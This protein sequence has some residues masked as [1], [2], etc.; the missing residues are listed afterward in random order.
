MLILFNHAVSSRDNDPSSLPYSGN[1]ELAFATV[2][3]VPYAFAENIRIVDD[4]FGD[5]GVVRTVRNRLCRW[6]T[7]GYFLNYSDADYHSYKA[8]RISYGTCHCH[9][10]GAGGVGGV[11]LEQSLLSRSKHRGV[12]D[13]SREQT[14]HFR[15]SDAS[16][17]IYT[18]HHDCTCDY[19]H[20]SQYVKSEATFLE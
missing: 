2:A 5:E 20:H 15:Q 9:I 4:V 10:I 13:R 3:Y 17:P 14:D 12:G 18:Q 6:F 8:E 1:H 16:H 7:G 11:Y 19:D